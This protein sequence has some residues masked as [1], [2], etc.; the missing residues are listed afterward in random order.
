MDVYFRTEKSLIKMNDR[1]DVDCKGRLYTSDLDLKK[2][3]PIA[4]YTN[5]DRAL[6]ILNRIDELLDKAITEN[7]AAISVRIPSE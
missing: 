1:L 4:K 7:K 3:S 6:E 5:I 2:V